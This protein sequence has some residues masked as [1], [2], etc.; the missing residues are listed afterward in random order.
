MQPDG[1]NEQ[2]KITVTCTTVNV[3]RCT[4]WAKLAVFKIVSVFPFISVNKSYN[5]RVQEKSN[6][7]CSNVLLTL[8]TLLWV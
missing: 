1:L 6:T 8:K 3:E 7:S 5:F 2:L 4:A